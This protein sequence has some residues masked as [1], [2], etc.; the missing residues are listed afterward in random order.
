MT[1]GTKQ[2]YLNRALA[3]VLI[4]AVAFAFSVLSVR[5]M[6]PS[7]LGVFSFPGALITFAIFIVLQMDL[8]QHTQVVWSMT[9]AFNTLIYSGL[10]ALCVEIT[11]GRRHSQRE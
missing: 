11:I 2:T 6:N 3:I 7:V 9:I 1:L 5:T 8:L 10:I 4:A